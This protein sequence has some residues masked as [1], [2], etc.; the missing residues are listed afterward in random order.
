ME[1]E[2]VKPFGLWRGTE[3]PCE[4][5]MKWWIVLEGVHE[6]ELSD[7]RVIWAAMRGGIE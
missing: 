2:V 6:I 7:E 4:R 3:S 1:N 5:E